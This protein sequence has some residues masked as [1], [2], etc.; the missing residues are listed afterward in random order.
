MSKF[1]FYSLLLWLGFNLKTDVNT[2]LV[3]YRLEMNVA[4]GMYAIL[5]NNNTSSTHFFNKNYKHEGFCDQAYFEKN[6]KK[7]DYSSL[8][9]FN[10]DLSYRNGIGDLFKFETSY[11]SYP[12]FVSISIDVVN[13]LPDATFHFFKSHLDDDDKNFPLLTYFCFC[14]K[15]DF[16][17]SEQE[18]S[19]VITELISNNHDKEQNISKHYDT[20]GIINLYQALDD[21]S[22][23]IS[24]ETK[25]SLLNLVETELARVVHTSIDRLKSK[26]EKSCN[27]QKEIKDLQQE[28]ELDTA[29]INKILKNEILF[30][31]INEKLNSVKNLLASKYTL[32]IEK[33]E[34]YSDIY[35]AFNFLRFALPK[36]ATGE[37]EEIQDNLNQL[38]KKALELG[39]NHQYLYEYSLDLRDSIGQNATAELQNIL[40][41][42]IINIFNQMT[43]FT[44]LKIT[45]GNHSKLIIAGICASLMIIYRNQIMQATMPKYVLKKKLQKLGLKKSPKTI[46]KF[47]DDEDK[48]IQ[49]IL[50]NFDYE[51][52][53]KNKNLEE[54]IKNVSQYNWHQSDPAKILTSL[55]IIKELNLNDFAKDIWAFVTNFKYEPS[56]VFSLFEKIYPSN[57]N[58]TKFDNFKNVL[59][60]SLDQIINNFTYE[61]LLEW[62]KLSQPEK[63][64]IEHESLYELINA[65]K[66][67]NVKQ[68]AQEKNFFRSNNIP[69]DK[70]TVLKKIHKMPGFIGTLEDISTFTDNFY[71]LKSFE[72][73]NIYNTATRKDAERY[74]FEPFDITAKIKLF[75][76]NYF[77]ANFKSSD[78]LKKFKNHLLSLP[79]LSDTLKIQPEPWNNRLNVSC[80]TY[81]KK[82]LKEFNENYCCIICQEDETFLEE[83]CTLPCC[84]QQIICDKCLKKHF[85]ENGETGWDN[86]GFRAEN[87]VVHASCPNCRCSCSIKLMDI[88][89][90]AAREVIAK[91]NQNR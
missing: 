44:K 65:F 28:I 16:F 43:L 60:A 47:Y 90:Q 55:K 67:N 36:I 7:I 59:S 54:I 17:V 35:S 71:K 27:T 22:I 53:I 84:K 81:Y 6:I 74:Y 9:F 13:K 77:E 85:K 20:L 80:N 89:P 2:T 24:S 76:S 1:L 46:P 50:D 15:K 19:A 25:T 82:T 23:W 40:E 14:F 37:I 41:K 58:S 38:N 42:N 26:V 10:F 45:C 70:Q 64:V 12:N 8:D 79:N 5:W 87:L 69:F 49:F 4:D 31:E 33:I 51:T 78:H 68:L 88:D 56:R 18:F 86:K 29:S 52:A 66:N 34:C 11:S 48:L 73:K 91:R 57:D 83:L 32:F 63:Q 72:K 61:N 30:L 21:S 39:W 3:P 62:R 75:Y